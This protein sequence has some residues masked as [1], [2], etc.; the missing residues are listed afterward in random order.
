[1][2]GNAGGALP[3]TRLGDQDDMR[4]PLPRLHTATNRTRRLVR[5]SASLAAVA[6]LALMGG[7]SLFGDDRATDPNTIQGRAERATAAAA[8]APFPN[9]AEVPDRPPP[10]TMPSVRQR[11]TEGLAADRSNAR[12]TAE[13]I[14][15]QGQT[16]RTAPVQTEAPAEAAL[17]AG[18]AITAPQVAAAPVAE[19][20][21]RP[22]PATVEAA[23]AEPAEPASEADGASPVTVDM[24]AVAA[25]ATPVALPAQLQLATIIF[26]QSS[27]GLDQRDKEVLR[28]VARVQR[29]YGGNL[30]VVGHSSGRT[31]EI[32]PLHH[33]IINFQL[34][35]HRANAVALAL[36]R[37][38][39]S[40]ENVLVEARGALQPIYL[41]SM[42]TGEAGNRRAEVYLIR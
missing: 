12:Y 23:A 41:E 24:T 42:P 22:T 34:S 32:D 20:V 29:Q 21:R 2:Y 39:V 6:V 26:A 38:G 31:R 27:Y 8:A 11:I 36:T 17:P 37:F 33:R 3:P 25:S 15:L 14:R 40:S 13:A 1:M 16:G 30:V 4:D 35:L 5:R 9:L 18:E 10:V 19:P 28:Q 7:C